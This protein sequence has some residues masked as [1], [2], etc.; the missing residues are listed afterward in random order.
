MPNL[1]RRHLVTTAAALPALAMPAVAD[2]LGHEPDPIFKAIERYSALDEA[3]Y[4]LAHYEDDLTES[5]HKLTPAP[6]DHRTPEMAAAVAA[7]RAARAELAKTVPST[8]AGMTAYLDYVLSE[9]DKADDL[10]F[11]SSGGVERDDEA[12]DFIRS[13]ARGA[14]LIAR[15]AAQS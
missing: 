5:G 8:P 9:S 12:M 6:G 15:K 4:A 1:S 3:Y 7:V 11:E 14:R 10:L 13:L 2:T